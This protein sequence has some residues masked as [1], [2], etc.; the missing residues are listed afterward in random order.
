MIRG[1]KTKY[2]ENTKE[3]TIGELTEAVNTIKNGE[4]SRQYKNENGEANGINCY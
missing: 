1:N 2:D 4:K 3:I